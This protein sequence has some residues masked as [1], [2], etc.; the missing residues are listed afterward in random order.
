[1]VLSIN[2]FGNICNQLMIHYFSVRLVFNVVREHAKGKNV[3]SHSRSQRKQGIMY[4]LYEYHSVC[5][6]Y[7]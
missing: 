2:S 5:A 1:M 4:D 6:E 3:A 7:V